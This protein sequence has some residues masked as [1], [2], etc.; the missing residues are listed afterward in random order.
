VFAIG[1]LGSSPERGVA[2]GD[3][4]NSRIS[5]FESDLNELGFTEVGSPRRGSLGT[6]EA[7]RLPVVLEGGVEYRIVGVCDIDCYDMDLIL[8]DSDQTEVVADFMD[9]AVPVLA[10]IPQVGGIYDLEV[11]M[12]YC[13]AEPCA[14]QVITYAKEADPALPDTPFGG[15]IIYFQTYTGELSEGDQVVDGVYLDSYEVQARA[16]QRIVV[17]LRSHP[18]TALVR[19]LDPDGRVEEYEGSTS[20]TGHSHLEIMALADGT[21]TI[22]AS[23]SSPEAQ[24]SYFLQVAVVG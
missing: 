12:V 3:D 22:H 14:F 24:G 5:L 10:F 17:D 2:P 9:D 4:M 6:E 11:G 21:Y 7:R 15:D 13:D 16:G 20:D 19:I 23:S 1:I 8:R 18:F